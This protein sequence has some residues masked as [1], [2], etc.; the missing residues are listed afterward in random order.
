[1]LSLACCLGMDQACAALLA[2]GANPDVRDKGGYTPLMHAAVHGRTQI[3]QLLVARGADASVRSLMGY[4]AFRIAPEHLRAELRSIVL[5]TQRRRHSRSTLQTGA[6][7][8]E[9]PSQVSWDVASASLY[10]SE[11]D[12]KSEYPSRPASRR[13][14][15]HM[16]NATSQPFHIMAATMPHGLPNT[17]AATCSSMVAYPE[18]LATPIPHHMQPLQVF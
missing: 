11:M 2:R 14:S 10:E 1:M 16:R 7:Y 17:A 13:P 5:S 6:S 3:F 4:S 18:S 8:D 9:L 12:S 15:V